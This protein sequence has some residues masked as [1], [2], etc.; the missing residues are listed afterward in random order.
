MGKILRLLRHALVVSYLATAQLLAAD[1]PHTLHVAFPVAETGFDPQALGDAYSFYVCDAIFD[2]LYTYDYFARPVRLVPNTAQALPEITDGGRTY[3]IKLRPGI[4]FAADPAFRGR[5]RELVAEDY[6]YSIKRIFDPKVR[7]YWLYLFENHLTGLDEVLRDAR[8]TGNLDYDG[9]IA[10]VQALDRYTLRIRFNQ[11]DYGFVHW[12]THS[13]TAAV[14]REVVE[15]NRDASNRVMDHPVGTGAYRL[16]EWVRGQRIVLEGN[17]DYRRETYPAPGPGNEP[18]DATIAKDNAGKMLPIVKRVEISIVEEA[19]PRLLAFDRGAFDYADVPASVAPNV[20]DG[21]TLKPA[22]AQRGIRLHRMIEPSVSF[23]FF[24]LDDPV[25]GG[26]TKEKIALRRAIAMGFDREAYIRL[27]LNG[28]GVPA[29]QPVPPSVAGHDSSMP[30]RNAYDPAAARALLDRL[31][32]RDRDPDGYRRTP[33]GKPL[34]L[35]KASTTSNTDRANDELWKRSMDAI[36]LRITFLKNKWPELNKMSEAGQLMMWNL[37]WIAT[38]SDG[39]TFYSILY[40]RNIGT[41]NDARLRLPDYDRLYEASRKLPDGP[42][43]TAIYRKLTGLIVD[44]APWILVD[45]PYANT[46]TQPWLKGYKQHPF[47]KH[48][49]KY[50]DVQR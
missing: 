43:R 6:V 27:L 17:P 49:W 21:D 12:L 16:A 39:D 48:Q 8:R 14:A 41:S 34:T 33:D 24:N 32:Y 15:A 18:G 2:T 7:S 38:V 1:A 13:A 37:G 35:V 44:Y 25:V 11:P 45:Y 26:Y 42:E 46:V 4:Y 10:G 40:S 9:K 19:Q 29:T 3:T 31:G 30:L 22:L 47:L 5:R 23:A 36:G 28:Q 20:L 50:Y